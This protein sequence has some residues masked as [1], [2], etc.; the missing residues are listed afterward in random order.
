MENK[1][2]QSL[3]KAYQIVK[4]L[5]GKIAKDIQLIKANDDTILTDYYVVATARST[6]HAKA[7]ADE[8]SFEMEKLDINALRTEG[9]D[10]GEW[11]LVDFGDVIA[12]VFIESAREY[13]RF[14]R[15]YPETSYISISDILG[16]N[17]TTEQ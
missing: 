3:E 12:H 9:R 7:L 15:L 1:E 16:A 5:D 14:E 6:T 13:Y 11:L 8:L 4:I 2:M 17:A 10:G